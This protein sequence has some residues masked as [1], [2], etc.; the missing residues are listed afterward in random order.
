MAAAIIAAI[1]IRMMTIITVVKSF[2][3]SLGIS[4]TPL[5]AGTGDSLVEMVDAGSGFSVESVSIPATI[6]SS[7]SVAS[8]GIGV[9][10]MAIV[11]IVESVGI[12][13]G[14]SLGIGSSHKC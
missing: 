8:V 7:K 11:A 4:I 9:I 3:V 5:S 2:G 12:S 6:V 14:L 1:G 13:L 10:A